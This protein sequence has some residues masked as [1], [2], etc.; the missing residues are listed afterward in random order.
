M[1]VCL[2]I[3]VCVCE[4]LWIS[5][6]TFVEA[7]Y[8]V[9]LLLLG[10]A[11]TRKITYKDVC[12]INLVCLS[13]VSV[14]R[15]KDARLSLCVPFICS[16]VP[17]HHCPSCRGAMVHLSPGMTSPILA[18]P[19][20]LNKNRVCCWRAGQGL[21]V[22]RQSA[23]GIVANISRPVWFLQMRAGDVSGTK[24]WSSLNAKWLPYCL[25]VSLRVCEGGG[26]VSIFRSPS[27]ASGNLNPII[28]TLVATSP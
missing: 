22:I 4:T 3:C 27:L 16:I 10:M 26:S 15:A 21:C 14:T 24:K 5:S 6:W 18:P 19:S 7:K 1:C 25:Y 17:P 28:F 13:D 8:S 2:Y 12:C 9:K 23:T 11:F 20:F